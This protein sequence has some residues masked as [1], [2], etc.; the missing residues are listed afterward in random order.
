MQ[1]ARRRTQPAVPATI[2]DLVAL[3][4]VDERYNTTCAGERMLLE[5]QE[6]GI[7]GTNLL[8]LSPSLRMAATLAT[9]VHLDGTFKSFPVVYALMQRRTRTSY[10]AVLRVCRNLLGMAPASVVC[11]Y[12]LGLV[13][14]VQAVFPAARAVWRKFQTLGLVRAMRE[15]ERLKI[16]VRMA[17]ALAFLPAENLE[18]GVLAVEGRVADNPVV[19]YTTFV[20]Y[21]RRFWLGAVGAEVVSVYGQP[22]RTNNAVESFHRILSKN[23]A[24][25]PNPLTFLV[26]LRRLEAS[27]ANDFV[28]ASTGH[29]IRRRRRPANLA[30]HTRI[31]DAMREFANG[32]INVT[33]YLIICSHAMENLGIVEGGEEELED[34]DEEEYPPIV[35]QFK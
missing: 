16:A 22:R 12:E 26:A 21:L 23:I 1:K 18:A 10:I 25:H 33:E 11:D 9:E 20:R 8:F 7:D 5:V 2:V 19:A 15:D 31:R 6:L 3:V 29:P 17:M 24:P 13:Q 4:Q 14:A 35:G 30:N 34:D 32:A 28:L 27:Q